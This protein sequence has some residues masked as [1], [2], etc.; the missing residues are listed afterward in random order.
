MRL[1]GR[2]GALRFLDLKLAW[3]LVNRNRRR[4]WTMKPVAAIAIGLGLLAMP[5]VAQRGGSHG[6]FSGH[7]GSMGHASAPSGHFSAPVSHG[8]PMGNFAPPAGRP[9]VPVGRFGPVNPGRFARGPY[10][11]PA[12]MRFGG[13]V[14][15]NQR[16]VPYT[17]ARGAG[18]AN[19][20]GFGDR[21]RDRGGDRDRH[22]RPY[23][24]GWGLGYS[25]GYPGLW[26]GYPF[27]LDSQC[28]L[29]CDS[30]DYGSYYNPYGYAGGYGAPDPAAYGYGQYGDAMTQYPGY[31]AAPEPNG[32]G[33]AEGY[34]QPQANDAVGNRQAYSGQTISSPPPPQPALKVILKDGQQLQVHNYLLTS[35][36]LTVLDDSYRQIPLDQIDVNATRQTNLA[37]GLDF[38]VPHAP[39]EATPG[40]VR[41]GAGSGDA[42]PPHNQLS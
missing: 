39:H 22:R 11:G 12:P 38:R 18:R 30:G 19:G 29:G 26:P 34:P 20:P 1:A 15:V 35:T 2:G 16:R 32:Y 37:N 42:K 6:G 28:I 13:A 33:T 40:Q 36:T 3:V 5:L 31:P 23:Y 4:L 8:A 27:L 25:Y 10:P 24:R 21:G 17:G 14:P 41:P 9:G 7:A